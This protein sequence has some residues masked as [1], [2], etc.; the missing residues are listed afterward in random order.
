MILRPAG[1]ADVGGI[2]DIDI[3]ARAAAL[4]NVR[5]AHTPAEVRG[6]MAETLLATRDVWVAEQDGLLGFM[7]LQPGWIDQLYLRPGFWR[8]GIG[9][10][11]MARAKALHPTGLHLY[12]FQC[13]ARARAFYEAQGFTAESFTDGAGNEEQEPDILYAWAGAAIQ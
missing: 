13:N 11:L 10:A 2:A 4:P 12:C 3:A 6:W 5:W 8:R 1:P 9:S 7:A